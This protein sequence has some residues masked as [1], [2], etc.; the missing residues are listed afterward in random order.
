MIMMYISS[1]IAFGLEE[2]QSTKEKSF[3]PEMLPSQ[4][5]AS[6]ESNVN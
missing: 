4:R 6:N 3:L 1:S 5:R 2:Q